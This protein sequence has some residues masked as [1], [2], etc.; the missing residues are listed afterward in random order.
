MFCLPL[1]AAVDH[2]YLPSQRMDASCVSDAQHVLAC[3]LRLTV[4]LCCT[5]LQVATELAVRLQAA[6]PDFAQWRHLLSESLDLPLTGGRCTSSQHTSSTSSQ[7]T[8]STSS[9]HTS[10]TSS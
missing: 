8:S 2:T 4:L 10:S 7:H 5:H 3:L 1:P 6:V 9:Q